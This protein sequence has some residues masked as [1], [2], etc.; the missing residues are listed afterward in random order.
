MRKTFGYHAG[1]LPSLA[2]VLREWIDANHEYCRRSKWADVPWAYN[3]RASLSTLAAAFWLSGGVALEEYA[4]VKGLAAGRCDLYG[5]IGKNGYVLEAKLLW[6][7]LRGRHWRR[8]I[9]TKLRDA[10]K[11]VRKTRIQFGE[12]RLAVVFVAPYLGGKKPDVS[13]I[14]IDRFVQSLAT[15]KDLC[16]AWT[17]PKRARGFTWKGF[18]NWR[19]P[20]AAIVIQPL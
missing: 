7:S 6:I 11:D 19:F 3:E 18:K 12:T 2:P 14:V 13:E 20:G 9:D 4:E 16:C 15:R 8:A 10:R 5:S 1:Q 17:F